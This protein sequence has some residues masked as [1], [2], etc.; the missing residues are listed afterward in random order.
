MKNKFSTRLGFT[1]IELL[2]YMGILTILISVLASIFGA[3]IDSKLESEATSSVDQ[4]GRYILARLSRDM[5]SA[6]S[7]A[8]PAA[9]LQGSALQIS[10]NS[11]AQTY[12]VNISNDLQITKSGQSD[13]LNSVDTSVSNLTFKRIGNGDVDDTIQMQFTLTS[14]IQRRA[15]T[16]EVK[17]FKTTFGRHTL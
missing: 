3:I 8:S 5:Q 14:K 16:S 12:A 7:I 17:S 6:T 9:G 13:N 2:L 15:G 4:D 11:I 10:V 1:T